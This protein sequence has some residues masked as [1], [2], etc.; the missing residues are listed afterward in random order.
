MKASLTFYPNP[1]KKNLKNGRIPVYLRVCFKKEKCEAR[2]NIEL[3]DQEVSK[4]DPLTMRV[5]ERN[6]A[7]NHSLNRLE[8]KF[9]DFLQLNITQLPKY[10]AVDFRDHIIGANL[11]INRAVMN[12]VDTYF[13]KAVLNNVNRRPGTIKNYRRSINHLR[14]FLKAKKLESITFDQL[15]FELAQDFKNYLVCTDPSLKRIGMTEV[16]AAGIIKK[17]RTIFNDAQAKELLKQNPF[18]QIRIKTKS[19][20]KERL[21]ID[22]VK[23]I[24]KT[25]LSLYPAKETYRD[26]F[27]FCIMTGLAYKDVMDLKWTN[28][29]KRENNIYKLSITRTKTG[30]ITESFLPTPAINILLKYNPEHEV[31]QERNVMPQRSNKEVNSQL[32]PIGQMA[33]IPFGLTT[34]T[35][36]HTFRQLLSEA[37]IEDIGLIK[38]LMGQSRRDDVDDVYYS[39]TETRLMKAYLALENYLKENL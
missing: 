37:G 28:I 15:N 33:K 12:F 27:I 35:A 38:R 30:V 7:L 10:S 1:P 21:T 13:E 6:S 25:D 8:Q 2:L 20:R 17:F 19:P 23:E 32:K 3:T 22:Q 31:N 39:I 9:Q 26:I 24:M 18:K 36:R 14:N 11:K 5:R 16:S 34:H 29:E 4:W